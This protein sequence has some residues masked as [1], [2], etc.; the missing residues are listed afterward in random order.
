M[1]LNSTYAHPGLSQRE[2]LDVSF[3]GNTESRLLSQPLLHCVP[4]DY[5]TATWFWRD[6]YS[7]SYLLDTL[8]N[9][10]LLQARL[11][12]AQEQRDFD[13]SRKGDFPCWTDVTIKFSSVVLNLSYLPI[14]SHAYF[15]RHLFERHLLVGHNRAKGAKSNEERLRLGS[16]KLCG[17]SFSQEEETYDHIYRICRHPLLCAARAASDHQLARYRRVLPIE[18]RVVPKVCQL[19]QDINGHRICI[20]VTGPHVNYEFYYATLKDILYRHL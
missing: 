4:L 18:E 15:E 6:E 12:C 5:L 20:L 14:P 9:R 1:F 8:N 3:S 11:R 2:V 7:G 13:C 17:S 19:V 16:C 10:S